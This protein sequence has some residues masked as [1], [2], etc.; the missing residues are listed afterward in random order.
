MLYADM[1]RCKNSEG[2]EHFVQDVTCAPEPMAVFATD[3]QLLDLEGFCCD[4][5]NLSIVGVDPTF[6]LGEFSITP[7]VYR[8]L[9]LEDAKSHKVLG[10]MLIQH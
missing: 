7:I 10:P 2:H 4:P 6:N 5:F 3:Q 8:R 9:L 1:L